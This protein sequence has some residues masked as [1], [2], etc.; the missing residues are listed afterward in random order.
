VGRI[1]TIDLNPVTLHDVGDGVSVVDALI[2]QRRS[3][4]RGAA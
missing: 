3:V 1:A 4:V 2:V